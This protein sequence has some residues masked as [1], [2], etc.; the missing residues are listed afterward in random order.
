MSGVMV[1]QENGMVSVETALGMG[2]LI[3][4]TLCALAPLVGWLYV[5]DAG[6]S[7]R[8]IAREYALHGQDQVAVMIEH[9]QS[10][11]S[12]VHVEREGEYVRV[13][14]SK[15]LPHMLSWIGVDLSRSQLA[16]VE[17]RG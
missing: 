5:T 12:E 4:V 14:V 6:H 1:R 2:S 15:K 7:A 8:E 9:V 13:T 17:P 10:D 16:M 11:G 3:A